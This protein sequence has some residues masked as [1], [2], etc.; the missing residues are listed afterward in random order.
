MKI[1]ANTTHGRVL[2]ALRAGRMDGSQIRDRVGSA[3][4]VLTVLVQDGL[5]EFRNDAYQ[6]TDAGREACPNRRDAELDPKH[7]KSPAKILQQGAAA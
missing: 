6:L 4:Y 1:N 5:V 7:Q 3:H 2:I